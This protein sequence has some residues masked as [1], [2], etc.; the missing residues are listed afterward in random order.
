VADSNTALAIGGIVL[1]AV[2]TQI[3]NTVWYLRKRSDDKRAADKKAEDDKK[4]AAKRAEDELDADMR[5]RI[6]RQHELCASAKNWVRDLAYWQLNARRTFQIQSE[7]SER[8][9]ACYEAW[10]R[11]KSGKQPPGAVIMVI[12]DLHAAEE[13]VLAQVISGQS[14]TPSVD[15]LQDALRRFRETVKSDLGMEL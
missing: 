13:E 4:A 8:K 7:A 6:E 5:R 9:G 11:A 2:L 12:N 15:E 3:G 14:L 10:D 1:G